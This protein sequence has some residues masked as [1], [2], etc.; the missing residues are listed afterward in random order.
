MEDYKLYVAK[1]KNHPLGPDRFVKDF[2]YNLSQWNSPWWFTATE[3]EKIA[4][5]EWALNHHQYH[6]STDDINKADLWDSKECDDK[7][8]LA[9]YAPVEYIEVQLKLED[10]NH[11]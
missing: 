1:F 8:T 10:I 9:K 3:E 5:F 7:L 6:Y 11:G 4:H 2:K